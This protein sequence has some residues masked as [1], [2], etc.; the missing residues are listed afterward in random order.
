MQLK[1][2][3][4]FNPLAQY[5]YITFSGHEAVKGWELLVW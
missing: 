5:V 2:C 4:I 1:L 3:E